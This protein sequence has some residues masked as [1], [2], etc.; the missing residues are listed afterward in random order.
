MKWKN[1]VAIFQIE[2]IF[3]HYEQEIKE[4]TNI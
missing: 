4:K 1:H 2:T 3:D